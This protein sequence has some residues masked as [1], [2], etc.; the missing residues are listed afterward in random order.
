MQALLLLNMLIV[1]E[2]NAC[3]WN[4]LQFQE[5]VALNFFL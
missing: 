4:M 1:I 3:F 5:V 2:N